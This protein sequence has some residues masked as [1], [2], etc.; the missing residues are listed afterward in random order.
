MRPFSLKT[1]LNVL[2][3]FM[4]KTRDRIRNNQTY[5]WYNKLECYISQGLPVTNTV[6]YWTH[7]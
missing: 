4:L 2:L 6:A 1:A 5:K 3:S 7:W